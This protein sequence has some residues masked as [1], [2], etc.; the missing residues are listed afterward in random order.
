MF[1]TVVQYHRQACYLFFGFYNRKS[2]SKKEKHAARLWQQR[3]GFLSRVR[4]VQ[5]EE[6]QRMGNVKF[7]KVK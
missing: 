4:E 7:G 5:E 6:A 3:W 2:V 1:H